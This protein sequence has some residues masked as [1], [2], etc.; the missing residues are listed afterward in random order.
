MRI[1]PPAAHEVHDTEVVAF[2]RLVLGI[3]AA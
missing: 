3:R 1:H 2:R